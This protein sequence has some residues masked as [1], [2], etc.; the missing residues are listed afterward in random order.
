M[1][2]ITLAAALLLPGVVVDAFVS[3][4]S[5]NI[6]RSSATTT[7]NMVPG[8]AEVLDFATTT[9]AAA[10]SM[11]LAMPDAETS[12]TFLLSFADQGQNLAGIFFQ[13][14]LLPYLAYLYFISFR[15]N[16]VP[17]LSNFGLQFL[18]LFVVMTIPSGIIAK[19]TYGVTL[20]N[21]DW[22]HGGAE[23]LLTVANVLLV[24]GFK[25]AYSGNSAN[26]N[27]DGAK[28]NAETPNQT[29]NVAR[30]LALGTF[31]A[32]VGACVIGP[33]LLEAHTPFLAGIGDLGGSYVDLPF[34]THSD[35]ENALSIPTWIIHYSSVIEF[36]IAMKLVWDYSEATGNEKWKGLTWGMLP[37]HASGICACTYHIFYNSM[38]LLVTMQAGF[39]ALGNLTCAIAAYRIAVS[40]GWTF[41]EVNPFKPSDTSPRGLVVDQTAA[42]PLVLPETTESNVATFGKLAAVSVVLSYAT[43]YGELGI[44]TFFTPN[45][46]L[47]LAMVL[48]IP[49]LTSAYYFNQGG[50][51]N[52]P[53]LPGSSEDGEGLSMA[54]V[55]KYGISGTVAYVLT[56]LAF[57]AVAF[58]VAS[59]ALYQ[60]TG[61]WP[62]VINDPT[63]R[64]TVLGFIFAGANVAR[65]LVPLR[66]GAA[67]ALA[68][69]VDENLL[70]KLNKNEA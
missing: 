9:T 3:P 4:N 43:K 62:D 15:G 6:L 57:W 14:S 49:A 37:L 65:L 29:F 22:L 52:M 40:N 50:E 16:R 46:P 10:T 38:Q 31:A 19:S 44:D 7:T 33:G 30:T 21:C 11:P 12:N 28:D 60:T 61:H 53:K 5:N 8:V 18:L 26:Q 35:P 42:L 2:R 59:T 58:P 41:Q 56:E 23:L 32:F 1:R 39:T 67:L 20:A 36:I 63:D 45:E 47:A 34:V 64:T 25:E 17:A 69:W 48:G 27:V 66:L 54:D 13:S 55:K 70:S 68:P 24:L 51:L